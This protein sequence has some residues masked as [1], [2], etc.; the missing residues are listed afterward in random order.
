[1]ADPTGLPDGA[2]AKIDDASD[3][4]FYSVPRFVTHIDDGAVAAVTAL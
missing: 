2:F 1:V 3:D 4:L